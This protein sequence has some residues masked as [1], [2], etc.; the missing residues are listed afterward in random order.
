M[1]EIH[2]AALA[3]RLASFV[4]KVR[5]LYPLFPASAVDLGS[6]GMVELGGPTKEAQ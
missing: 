4:D 6:R 3:E 2:D 1:L 5:A